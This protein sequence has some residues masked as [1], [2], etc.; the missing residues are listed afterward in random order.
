MKRLNSSN[1][2]PDKKTSQKATDST[3]K[4]SICAVCNQLIENPAEARHVTHLS[5]PITAHALCLLRLRRLACKAFD[6]PHPSPTLTRPLTLSE[7]L[8][9]KRPRTA[10]EILACLAYYLQNQSTHSGLIAPEEVEEHLLFTGF[11]VPDVHSAFISATEDVALFQRRRT[12][13]KTVYQL[14]QEGIRIVERLP[15][16]LT[17]TGD[18]K[19]SE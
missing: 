11:K 15:A 2:S 14:T 1:K 8:L 10:A 17:E 16:F 4:A 3:L 18:S 19:T 7:F 5:K 9:S 12:K 6:M 13:G